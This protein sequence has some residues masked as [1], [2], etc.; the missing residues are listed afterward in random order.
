VTGSP[1]SRYFLS[2]G[3]TWIPASAGMT[4]KGLLEILRKH[5]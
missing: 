2:L 5:Q 1:E 4:E 3:K